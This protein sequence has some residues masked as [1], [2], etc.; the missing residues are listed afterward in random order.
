VVTRDMF[1]TKPIRGKTLRQYILALTPNVEKVISVDGWTSATM[2]YVAIFATYMKDGMHKESLLAVAPLFNE[3][4][5]GAGQHIEFMHATLHLYRKAMDNVVVLIG[6][7]C[8]TNKKIRT[9]QVFPSLD[10]LAIDS[11]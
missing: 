1:K 8:S 7:N 9:T 6:D 3:E 5:L 11:I 10:V 4:Q 2:H